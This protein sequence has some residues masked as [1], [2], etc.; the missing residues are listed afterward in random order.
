MTSALEQWK[1]RVVSVIC[2]DGRTIVGLL[3]VQFILF[4]KYLHYFRVS[5]N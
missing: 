5:I 2:G 1:D 3:K 4:Q